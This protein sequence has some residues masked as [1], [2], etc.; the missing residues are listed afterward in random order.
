[1]SFEVNGGLMRALWI[2]A[3]I[4]GMAAKI[5]G[6]QMIAVSAVAGAPPAPV[7]IYAVGT[8]GT[9]PELLPPSQTSAFIDTCKKRADGKV[10]LAVVIDEKGQPIE[11][12]YLH[13]LGTVLDQIAFDTVVADRFKPGMHDGA[14]AAVAESVE[15]SLHGCIVK[16]K[17][18][19][20]KTA[21]QLWLRSQPEQSFAPLP[22]PL[23]KI[24]FADLGDLYPAGRIK[25]IS[26]D[27]IAGI[28]QIGSGVSAPVP[29]YNVEAEFSDAAR[30]AKY[31]GKCLLSLVV[32]S[33]GKPQ[34]IRLRR[35]LGMGLDEKAIEA[36]SKYR[37]KPAM[38]HGQPVAVRVM[39]EVNFRIY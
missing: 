16:T 8:D 36:V 33:Q 38:N 21:Y 27:S 32:D 26:S 19:K 10:T 5:S 1:L 34:D 15:V 17:D 31:G 37:F 7:K 20:G 28:H 14:P 24:I 39:I 13:P 22:V 35:P 23:E 25:N 6:G 12:T 29:V 3:L 2:V 11:L 18:S 30:N 9:A 4:V